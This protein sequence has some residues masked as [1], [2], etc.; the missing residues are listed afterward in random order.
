MD[1]NNG[2][3]IK[4]SFSKEDIV[5]MLS[6]SDEQQKI[7]I[8]KAKQVAVANIGNKVFLRGLIEYSNICDKNCFYCGIRHDNHKQKRYQMLDEE[9]LA[10]ASFAYKNNYGSV[11]IQS[12]ER[13]DKIFIDK[14]ERLV[15]EIKNISDNKLGITL[16]L[17]EQ[18]I[19]TYKR[20]FDAGA[21]RYLLRIETSDRTLFSHYHPSNELHSY[22]KRLEALS[23]IKKIGYQLG[24]GVMIGLPS[25]TV[26]NLADDLLF[27]RHLN[28]D[29]VGMGP[30]LE[31]EQTP[32][33]DDKDLLL[34]KTERFN[35]TLKMIS[36]LRLMMPDINIAATTAMQTIDPFGRE[37]AI[38]AG[39]NIIM[40][41][42][43][44]VK[45]RENYLLYDGKPCL[46]EDSDKCTQCMFLRIKSTGSEI[47]LG[48]WGD[49]KHFINTCF[50]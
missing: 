26:E 8:D 39:A 18:H 1:F 28:A 43:T 5:Q 9:V 42:L 4:S 11:V 44:P 12:G 6:L 49:S 47:G 34:S 3:L 40:P 45:Y 32:M 15:K 25:Q 38:G 48:E 35:L 24:T 7:L 27:I 21:H 22:D 17:G 50:C 19:D 41:N 20:W 46:N 29:M 23:A 31:H 37:K 13:T 14:I 16:S 10:C 33:F 36:I 2:I 30:Y